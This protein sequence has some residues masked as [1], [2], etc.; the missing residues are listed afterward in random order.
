MSISLVQKDEPEHKDGD[1]GG[2]GGCYRCEWCQ[3]EEFVLATWRE[4]N[5][6]ICTGCH[7]PQVG[8]TWG[9]LDE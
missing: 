2:E 4:L 6:G 3:G 8:L 9:H 5:V 1:D 7:M